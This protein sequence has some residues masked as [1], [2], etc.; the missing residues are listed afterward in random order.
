MKTVKKIKSILFRR[1]YFV[2]YSDEFVIEGYFKKGIQY[3]EK[4]YKTHVD[5]KTKFREGFIEL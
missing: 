1:K 3:V 5:N 4:S 2:S